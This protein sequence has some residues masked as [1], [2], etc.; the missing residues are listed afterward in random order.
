MEAIKINV[1]KQMDGYTFWTLPST[2]N[3]IKSWN[4]KF[5]PA[6]TISVKFDIKSEFQFNFG[7][8]AALLGI[9][10]QSDLIEKVKEILFVDTQTGAVLHSH[11]VSA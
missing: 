3:L 9:E 11:S 8:Y 2:R 1:S 6:N 7:I 4:P 10:N 5:S